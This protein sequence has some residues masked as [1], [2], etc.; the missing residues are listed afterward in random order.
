MTAERDAER[1]ENLRAAIDA[2]MAKMRPYV[3]NAPR[4]DRVLPATVVA[5]WIK[6]P[7]LG[8]RLRTCPAIFTEEVRK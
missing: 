8:R 4:A 7:L 1:A 2:D 6:M 5:G 3:S